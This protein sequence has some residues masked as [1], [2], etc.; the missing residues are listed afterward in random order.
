YGQSSSGLLRRKSPGL[1]C[2][3]PISPMGHCAGKELQRAVTSFLL[4][5]SALPVV[6]VS[7]AP[8][9]PI[10]KETAL[11]CSAWDFYP[12]DIQLSWSK[13]SQLLTNS[14]RNDSLFHNSNGSYSYIS[15]LVVSKH[16]WNE[17]T[18]FSCQV[19][20]STLKMPVVKNFTLTQSEQGKW[21][22]YAGCPC[23]HGKGTH[24][25]CSYLILRWPLPYYF[26]RMGFSELLESSV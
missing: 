17:F 13:G 8:S 24:F 11:T 15:N 2:N 16:D 10:D 23:C 20:H 12:G 4:S 21:V 7:L 25:L 14:T 26:R 6:E 3:V 18:Q 19:N 1:S 22:L 5:F 9:S